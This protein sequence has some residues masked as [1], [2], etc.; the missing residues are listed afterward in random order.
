MV[1]NTPKELIDWLKKQNIR[2]TVFTVQCRQVS[3]PEKMLK[4]TEAS[5]HKN[6]EITDTELL[7]PHTDKQLADHLLRKLGMQSKIN[8]GPR[9]GPVKPLPEGVGVFMF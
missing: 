7:W 4:E 9:K 3:G 6:L 1:S 5:A 2:S 8:R